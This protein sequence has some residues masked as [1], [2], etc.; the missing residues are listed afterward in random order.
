[1]NTANDARQIEQVLSQLAQL[2]HRAGMGDMDL[3][4]DLRPSWLSIDAWDIVLEDLEAQR[5]RE[6]VRPA[7]L[8]VVGR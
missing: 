5:Y 6:R 2:K 3:L 8:R 1:M 7:Q 4:E